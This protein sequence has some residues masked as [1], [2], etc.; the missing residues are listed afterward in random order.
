MISNQADLLHAVFD[1]AEDAMLVVDG[2]RIRLCNAAAER[3]LACTKEALLVKPWLAFVPEQ[4]ANGHSS[5]ETWRTHTLAAQNGTAQ[6]FNW[7]FRDG[8][9]ALNNTQISLQKLDEVGETMLV[10]LRPLDEKN[11]E[12]T[13][14]ATLEEKFRSIFEA[15]P[16]YV[17]VARLHD[18]MIFEANAGFERLS[19]W[20]R[21]EAIGRSVFELNLWAHPEE[22]NILVEQVQREGLVHNF[23]ML[24]HRRDGS[25]A[26]VLASVGMLSLNGQAHYVAILRDITAE[27]EVQRALAASE[28][29]LRTI[30]EASPYAI[31]ITRVSDL[32]YLDI[33]PAFER[34]FGFTTAEI[35]GKTIPEAGFTIPEFESFVEQ[36]RL[37]LTVGHIENAEASVIRRDGRRVYFLYSSRTIMLDSEW[38][39]MTITADVSHQKAVEENLR[40]VEQALRESEARFSALFQASP[41]ALAVF[42]DDAQRYS[43]LQINDAWRKAFLYESEQVIGKS[44]PDFA[45]QVDLRDREHVLHTLRRDGEIRDFECWLRRADGQ[46]ILCSLSG[47]TLTVGKHR[48]LLAAYLD[49]TRQRETE[50]ALHQFNLT[51]EQRVEERTRE[52]QHAQAELMR[53][54]KLASLGS[55]VAGIAHELNTPIGNS[56]TVAT[57]LAE[58]TVDINRQMQSGLRRSVLENYLADAASGTILL[59]RNLNRAAELIQSFKSIAVDRVSDQRRH[60]DLQKIVNET[61]LTL[62]ASLKNKPCTLLAKVE[63]NLVLD[64]YPGPLEQVIVNLVNNAVMHGLDGKTSG[65]VRIRGEKID[66]KHLRLSVEDDGNGIDSANLN[67]IFDPFFT[68]KLGK[69]GSGLGLHIVSN[70]VENILGGS[71]Q[72][73]SE[74]GKGTRML[75]QLPFQAPNAPQGERVH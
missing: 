66:G 50:A 21:E 71:I 72:V 60:F 75:L 8:K 57:T 27:V 10:T 41:V 34:I 7:S 15:N 20:R 59:T 38:V 39:I 3:L 31:A 55:L 19:G 17:I 33:N 65:T 2:D 64:S 56:L 6:H 46:T 44:T 29:R 24:I 58:R 9:Q 68:T 42:Y 53:S 47:C 63:E 62:Q 43:L 35:I 49:V 45:F 30:Y 28:L 54:E 23:P 61:L 48:L 73:D 22:R 26:N 25:R 74:I 36:T 70:I 52:L 4:Q 51:L 37:L 18:G 16:D 5:Q 32:T 40:D 69:G 1:K 12:T 13:A 11:L 67:R 14:A